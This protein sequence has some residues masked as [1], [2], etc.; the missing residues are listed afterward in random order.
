MKKKT[1][2][3]TNTLAAPGVFAGMKTQLCTLLTCA[4]FTAF[5]TAEDL[6]APK[7]DTNRSIRVLLH[8]PG[9]DRV[10]DYPDVYKIH[11]CEP[12]H[13]YFETNDGFLVS[14][15][16][17]YTLIEPRVNAIS[18]GAPVP[19]NTAPGQRFFDPK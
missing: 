1:K 7:P 4:V 12:T 10:I 5:A 15:R 13:I 14:H 19:S 17:S 9:S 11:A 2:G 18:R 16:G 6:K 8:L 3:F